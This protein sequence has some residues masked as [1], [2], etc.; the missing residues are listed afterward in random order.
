MLE[1]GWKDANL[2]DDT[3]PYTIDTPA[4][5]L[6]L[7]EITASWLDEEHWENDGHSIWEYEES[8][9]RHLIQDISNLAIFYGWMLQNPDVYLEFYDSY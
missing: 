1:F 7:I 6:K 2:Y 9:R 3:K 4:Q 5:V 8:A